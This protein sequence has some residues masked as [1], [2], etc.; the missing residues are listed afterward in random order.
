MTPV[1]IIALS[2]VAIL[3]AGAVWASQRAQGRVAAWLVVEKND[4]LRILVLGMIIFGAFLITWAVAAGVM[5]AIWLYDW[6]Q[7]PGQST[8]WLGQGAPNVGSTSWDIVVFTLLEIIKAVG[9]ILVL[10]MAGVLGGGALGFLFGH[11]EAPDDANRSKYWRLNGRLTQILD[12]LTKAIVGVG[13]VEAKTAWVSFIAAT[14]TSAGWLFNSRHGSPVIIPAAIAGGAVL[15]FLLLYLYSIEV[16]APLIAWSDARIVGILSTAM[17]NG[18]WIAPRISRSRSAHGRQTTDQAT[19][20]QIKEA[21]LYDA[22]PFGELIAR[23]D[24]TWQEIWNWARA[25]AVLNKYA[26]AATGY[27]YLAG[28]VEQ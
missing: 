1:Q 26:E 16:L 6:A 3:L 28:M 23:P 25:K 13:L 27:L 24:V 20:E 19:P 8:K 18:Q 17:A 14:G 5:R 22:M 9:G 2:I 21:R 11:P 7:A 12:W 15:G 10:Y 4:W